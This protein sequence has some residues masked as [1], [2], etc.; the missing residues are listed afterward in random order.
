MWRSWRLKS[1]CRWGRRAKL[2]IGWSRWG[3]GRWRWGW[4]SIS[5]FAA[6]TGFWIFCCCIRCCSSPPPL[7]E[8]TLCLRPYFSP[9]FRLRAV[10]ASMRI[11]A[12]GRLWDCCSRCC[13]AFFLVCRR[14]RSRRPCRLPGRAAWRRIVWR[15]GTIKWQRWWRYRSRRGWR[16]CRYCGSTRTFKL[17]FSCSKSGFTESALSGISRQ[18]LH[19]FTTPKWSFPGWTCASG[20]CWPDS[21]D[22]RSC[23]GSYQ[24]LF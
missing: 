10:T 23:P 7:S 2:W 13:W 11:F 3:P 5:I 9:H 12:S 15:R 21:R 1:W 22:G 19:S 16:I 6:W 8:S 18:T 20:G 17:D 14:R 24:V 4:L